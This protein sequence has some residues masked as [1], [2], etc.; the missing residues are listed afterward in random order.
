MLA[1]DSEDANAH[2]HPLAEVFQAVHGENHLPPHL[3]VDGERVRIEPSQDV[4]AIFHKAI[5]SKQRLAKLAGAYQDG[6]LGVIVAQKALQL[7][8]KVL[9][10]IAHLWPARAADGGK[11]FS[12][13]HM[14]HVQRFC[15]CCC[16]DVLGSFAQAL[17]VAEI[18]WKPLQRLL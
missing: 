8:D 15:Y 14:V 11:V 10:D 6:V 3:R 2:L 18:N 5:V 13:H 17:Q 4:E 16:R 12:H 9:A 1:G 7:V